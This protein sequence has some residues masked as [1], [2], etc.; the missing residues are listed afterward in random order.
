MIL[1]HTVQK[2]TLTSEASK[3][4]LMGLLCPTDLNR[5]ARVDIPCSLNNC[6]ECW[7]KSG[8]I[9]EVANG[10]EE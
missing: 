6:K 7:A 9:L 1:P 2:L 4:I 3:K 5:D 8:I 10:K